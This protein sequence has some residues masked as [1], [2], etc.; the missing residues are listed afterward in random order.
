M[1]ADERRIVNLELA[2]LYCRAF[3]RFTVG[4]DFDF[5]SAARLGF[6]FAAM[7]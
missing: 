1:R 6:F 3:G 7:S 5:F 4:F 2:A